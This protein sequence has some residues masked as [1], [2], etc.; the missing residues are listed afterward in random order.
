M[1]IGH[2]LLWNEQFV[3]VVVVV[4]VVFSGTPGVVEVDIV[5]GK[6][7]SHHRQQSQVSN[8]G[9]PEKNF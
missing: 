8:Q 2:Q 1:K 3:V 5:E 4:V 6:N 7:N 9:E